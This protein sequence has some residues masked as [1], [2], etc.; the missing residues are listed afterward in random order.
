MMAGICAGATFFREHPEYKRPKQQLSTFLSYCDIINVDK[1]T[2]AAMITSNTKLR[3]HASSALRKCAISDPVW[4]ARA[5]EVAARQLSEFPPE[6]VLRALLFYGR[7][8]EVAV[9][10]IGDAGPE[11][12]QFGVSALLASAALRLTSGDSTKATACCTFSLDDA[13]RPSYSFLTVLLTAFI[14][15]GAVVVPLLAN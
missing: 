2:Q 12:V 3:K 7:D 8:L 13:C 4:R 15:T 5:C 14:C 6:A 1:R 9:T 11:S 10:G